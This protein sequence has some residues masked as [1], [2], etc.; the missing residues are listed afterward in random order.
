VLQSLYKQAS[1]QTRTHDIIIIILNIQF[2]DSRRSRSLES[3]IAKPATIY[4]SEP[5]TI[6]GSSSSNSS[7][8]MEITE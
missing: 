2:Q 8:N 3:A 7:S 4:E 5:T 1:K 6:Y